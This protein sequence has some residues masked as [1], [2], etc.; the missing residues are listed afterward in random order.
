MKSKTPF[1][2]RQ[3]TLRDG[4]EVL[5][6]AGMPDDA[7]ALLAYIDRCLPDF[8]PYVAMD[9]G[10]FTMDEPQEREWLKAQQQGLGSLSLY[11]WS[12]DQIVASVN[13]SCR[14][15]RTRLSH[16]G[17]I[18]MSSDK[19][20]WGSG[21]GSAMMEALIDWA[22]QNPV[23]ELL[24]LDVFADNERAIRLYTGMGF[25]KVGTVP[26]RAKYADGSRKDGVIMYRLLREG[27]RGDG[28]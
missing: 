15:D 5:L 18:G 13:C 22:E 25:V 20:Y 4:R 27:R 28:V 8:A 24:E 21:L 16:L 1:E 14:N 3:V 11:A 10:E 9:L 7:P 19:A 12:G 23:L 17:H 2:P 26:G 6:R